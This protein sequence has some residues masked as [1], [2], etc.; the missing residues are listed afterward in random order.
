MGERWTFGGAGRR[1]EGG[2]CARGRKEVL[3]AL[4]AA[5]TGCDLRQ[6]VIYENGGDELCAHLADEVDI[7]RQA[8][9]TVE[10]GEQ[11]D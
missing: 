10:G 3:R 6:H 7:G 4:C 1:C 8:A 9:E 2:V 11:L 5:Q